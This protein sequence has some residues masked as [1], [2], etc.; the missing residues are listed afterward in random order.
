MRVSIIIATKNRPDDLQMTV[1]SILHQKRLPD[2][3]IIVDQSDRDISK[4]LIH[5]IVNSYGVTL[6]LKYLHNPRVS[7]AATARNRGFMESSGDIVIF[8]DDDVTLEADFVSSIVETY[9]R[10]PEIDGLGGVDIG[11]ESRISFARTVLSMLFHRGPFKDERDWLN[12]NWRKLRDP[13]YTTVLSSCLMSFR[14]YVL[15]E[16]LFDENFVGYSLGEDFD[17]TYR[18]SK[19]Y[20]LAITPRA[21]AWHR[22][23]VVNRYSSKKI[24]EAK[25]CSRAY[26]YQKR[27]EKTIWNRLCYYWLNLGFLFEALW[28]AFLTRSLDPVKGFISGVRKARRGLVGVDFLT[29]EGADE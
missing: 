8:L 3:L 6:R 13:T 9:N 16:F 1:K 28:N 25:V 20:T 22:L 4:H 29:F 2:E 19:K 27:V 10:H 15:C 12:R 17:L 21:K 23:S 11:T 5:D 24:V 14:R 7:G 26:F 18:C